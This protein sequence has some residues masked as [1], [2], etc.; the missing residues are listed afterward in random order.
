MSFTDIMLE[1]ISTAIPI[2]LM[3]AGFI[4]VYLVGILIY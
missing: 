2:I 4:L 1:L 3:I